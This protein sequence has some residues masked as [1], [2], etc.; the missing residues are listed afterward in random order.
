MLRL[1]KL[2]V[3]PFVVAVLAGAGFIAPALAE[4]TSQQAQSSSM[5]IEEIVVTARKREESA[6]EVPV[7]ITALTAEMSKATIRDLTDLN[8]Y[9]PNVRIDDSIQRNNGASIIIRGIS[10]VRTD[11]NSFDAPIGVMIDGIY[12]G[13]MAGQILEN[14]DIERVEVL[15][16]PQG[17]L[18]GKNTV[19]G[20]IHA[21]RSRPTGELGAKLRLATGKYDQKEVRAVLNFPL[22]EDQLA[23]KVFFTTIQ[24][25]GF[26]RN[27]T[28][29]K[30]M[31]EKDYENYGV[32]LLATPNDRFEALF[33]AEKFDDK[34]ELG[35]FMGNWNLP[36]G[37]AAAP[38]AGSKEPNYSGGF[39][40][41][42]K[43]FWFPIGTPCRE[44]LDDIPS[45]TT[46][47]VNNPAET[48]VDAYTLNMSFD[49]NDN[50][51]LVSV[52]GYRDMLENTLYDFDG[53]EANHITIEKLN[54][55]DQFSQEL[56]VEGSW[57]NVEYV[58]GGYYWRS[59]F[60]RDWV[61]GG[62]FWY[63]VSQIDLLLQQV[64]GIPKAVYD[65]RNNTWT[66]VSPALQPYVDRY[67]T[68]L[69][70]CWS[71]DRAAVFGNVWCDTGTPL[72]GM[73]DAYTQR[74]Y[75]E[76]VTK[77]VAF[78]AQADWEFAENWILTAG[79]RWTEE[80]KD[81]SAAQAYLAPANRQRIMNFPE[82]EWAVLNNKWDEISPK[83]GLSYRWTD[84]VMF[85]ASYSEGFHSG[86]YFGTN[87]NKA[88]FERDQY[89]PE[90]AKTW[91]AGV[92]SQLMDNRIQLN[93]TVFFNDFTDKQ[94]SSVFL[95][96]STNTVATKF[97]NVADAEYKGVE[98]EFQWVMSEYVHMFASLGWLDAKYKEFETDLNPNDGVDLIEDATH[99]VPRAAPEFTYAV[100]GTLSIP[101]G[102]GEFEVFVKYD[103][104]DTIETSL[105]NISFNRVD[106]RDN[107]MAS[108]GYNWNSMSLVLY[109]RN[110]TDEQFE[111]PAVIDPLFAPSTITQGT[112]WGVEFSM[113]L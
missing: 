18:F 2:L 54:D 13:S 41:C 51:R 71:P 81:F 108:A 85:Y 72:S 35:A 25:D 89:G 10:A 36:P 62:E 39:W 19:G 107:L 109:G 31:P 43:P 95:D 15:R 111:T 48:E 12:L 60:E 64:L 14:F 1:T 7:A 80:K 22:I 37:V 53:T 26:M 103:W 59:E 32:T 61:T 83:V 44:S 27:T 69:E 100:G 58:V 91:E 6:Q 105:V 106:A 38:P 101:A 94:E 73:G 99:L 21:I 47:D 86:G 76:Q 88:D 45:T 8:G 92:K 4:E 34:S 56:R 16:G 82:G 113:E 57:N 30:R 23:A 52:T 28:L 110:L 98:V 74:L 68:P 42:S 79:L 5:V 63:S 17:T 33:T 50:M 3:S 67:P 78:Y 46:I 20:V 102:P 70:M 9:A 40:A 97:D 55:F 77:S 29:D 87:Q 90:Y 96:N 93:A 112:V 65:L 104:V 49:L 24:N 11:D 75:E 66:S 84:D